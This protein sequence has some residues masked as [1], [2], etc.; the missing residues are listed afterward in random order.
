MNEYLRDERG[1]VRLTEEEMYTS[2]GLT[3]REWW[4]LLN[5][6]GDALKKAEKYWPKFREGFTEG[7]RAA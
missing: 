2:G 6:L 7:W 4:Q 5:T 1:L 3:L